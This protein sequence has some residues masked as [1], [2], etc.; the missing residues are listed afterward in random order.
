MQAGKKIYLL[1]PASVCQLVCSCPVPD[2]SLKGM[3][4]S[5]VEWFADPQCSPSAVF[6]SGIRFFFLAWL[7]SWFQLG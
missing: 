7:L 2:F 4:G 1:L 5:V 6:S 3:E